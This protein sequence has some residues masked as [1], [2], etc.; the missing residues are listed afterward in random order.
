[1]R[2]DGHLLFW[3]LLLVSVVVLVCC[4]QLLLRLRKKIDGFLGVPPKVD[5]PCGFRLLC[6]LNLLDRL[7]RQVMRILEIRMGN[8][9]TIGD[10][11]DKSSRTEN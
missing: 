7:L 8:G 2:S 3:L 9:V 5:S 1:M 6:A 4:D 11:C 10:G